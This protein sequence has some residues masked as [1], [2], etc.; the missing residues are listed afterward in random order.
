[1]VKISDFIDYF[2]VVQL[3]LSI[4]F[5]VLFHNKFEGVI[6]YFSVILFIGYWMLKII[7]N[8]KYKAMLS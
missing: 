1:M 6:V 4:L 7:F 3:V 8:K 5:L 2:I